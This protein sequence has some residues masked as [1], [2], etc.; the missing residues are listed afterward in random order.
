LIGIAFYD[1]YLIAPPAGAAALITALL[2]IVGIGFELVGAGLAATGN[3][4]REAL[5]VR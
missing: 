3:A 2:S 1:V 5:H 4:P